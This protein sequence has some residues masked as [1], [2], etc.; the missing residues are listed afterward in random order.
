MVADPFECDGGNA[1]GARC[2][3]GQYSWGVVLCDE[4]YMSLSNG[5][6]LLCLGGEA[7]GGILILVTWH[8]G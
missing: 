4:T 1:G 5:F 7:C 2:L 6:P 8:E 3:E